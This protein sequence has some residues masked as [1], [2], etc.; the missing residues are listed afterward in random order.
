MSNLDNRY[1]KIQIYSELA[2]VK[3]ESDIVFE[4]TH[5]FVIEFFEEEFD[6]IRNVEHNIADIMHD[7]LLILTNLLTSLYEGQGILDIKTNERH[8]EIQLALEHEASKINDVM[9]EGLV[10]MTLG[11]SRFDYYCHT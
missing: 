11:N 6:F 7:L 5:P 9:Q 2:P 8:L 3:G 1:P 10:N 4:S